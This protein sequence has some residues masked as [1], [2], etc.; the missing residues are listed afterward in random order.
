M[1]EGHPA[2]S[3]NAGLR[4]RLVDHGITRAGA[5]LCAGLGLGHVVDQSRA[6]STAPINS[7][8]PNENSTQ[9]VIAMRQGRRS[10]LTCQTGKRSASRERGNW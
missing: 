2:P 7:Q 6:A 8:V 10:S 9:A 4:A 5:G 3:E 1:A